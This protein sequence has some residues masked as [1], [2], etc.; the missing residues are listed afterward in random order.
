MNLGQPKMH[1]DVT[2][3]SRSLESTIL[4]KTFNCIEYLDTCIVKILITDIG[5]TWDKQFR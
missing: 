5:N 3:A 2:T 4:H 1:Y